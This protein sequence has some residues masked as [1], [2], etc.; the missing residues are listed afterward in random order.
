MGCG[1]GEQEED[2]VVASYIGSGEGIMMSMESQRDSVAG[3]C[4][5]AEEALKWV[6][7]T[8]IMMLGLDWIGF[9][10]GFDF[11]LQYVVTQFLWVSVL[12]G[13]PS[14][15]PRDCIWESFGWPLRELKWVR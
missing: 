1:E 6:F 14:I 15:L 7:S 4:D 5:E 10:F 2:V 13:L 3:A 12:L 8:S 11:E 9:G